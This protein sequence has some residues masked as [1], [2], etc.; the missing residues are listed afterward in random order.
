MMANKEE[1]DIKFSS[2]I[3]IKNCYR[4]DRISHGSADLN[5]GHCLVE[6]NGDLYLAD[7]FEESIYTDEG[8]AFDFS[9][10]GKHESVL[11]ITQEIGLPYLEFGNTHISYTFID[12]IKKI[13]V[14]GQL[15]Q[16]NDSNL[17]EKLK[18][19]VSF[20]MTTCAENYV[21]Y[22]E[23]N[24][25]SINPCLEDLKKDG[26]NISDG[27]DSVEVSKDT[28]PYG[29][30][31]A[32]LEIINEKAVLHLNGKDYDVGELIKNVQA[33]IKQN[34]FSNI[35]QEQ[36]KLIETLFEQQ[37]QIK[38]QEQELSDLK[39]QIKGEN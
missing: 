23:N 38:S 25:I 1:N 22:D 33:V 24:N 5:M 31:T 8:S 9:C 18:E 20:Y 19:C 36:Q 13:G 30:M 39:S 29:E 15:Y 27:Y 35:T 7:T 3:H 28:M 6:Y 14:D 32:T 16:V 2:F 10:M 17:L 11:D 12:G 4:Y 26:V 37:K 21:E 34:R